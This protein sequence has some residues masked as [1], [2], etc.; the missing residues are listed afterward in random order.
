MRLI[1][2]WEADLP[3]AY[4]LQMSFP[5][6]ETGF[7]NTAFGL[8]FEQFTAYVKSREERSRGVGLPEGYV[9]DTVYILEDDQGNYVGIFNLRHYLNDALRNGAGH[10]GYGIRKEYRG[11]GYASAGLALVLEKARKLIP[12]E[13]IYFSVDKD[14]PASLK[15]QMKNGAKIHHENETEYF[16]RIPKEK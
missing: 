10:I 12:E 2:L 6:Q 5:E 8:S 15:V 9:P 4:D 3:K 16:T 7:V 13:A 1:P 11:R 14:N